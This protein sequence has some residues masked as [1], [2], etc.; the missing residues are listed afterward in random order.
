MNMKTGGRLLCGELV[1]AGR[2]ALRRRSPWKFR[3]GARAA[4]RPLEPDESKPND[5]RAPKLNFSNPFDQ[6]G[7]HMIPS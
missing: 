5:A 6:R 2:R 4:Q 1:E 7:A 3:V